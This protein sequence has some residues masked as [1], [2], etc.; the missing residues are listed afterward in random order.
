M[1]TEYGTHAAWDALNGLLGQ[2]VDPKHVLNALQDLQALIDDNNALPPGLALDS[3]ISH[4]LSQKKCLTLLY[5]AGKMLQNLVSD[6]CE[7]SLNRNPRV[8]SKCLDFFT[9]LTQ[10]WSKDF[11]SEIPRVLPVSVH[12]LGRGGSVR[13]AACKLLVA[14]ANA[15]EMEPKVILETI[16]EQSSGAGE[17]KLRAEC[18]MALQSVYSST[19]FASVEVHA[20]ALQ[21]RYVYTALHHTPSREL[22]ADGLVLCVL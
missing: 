19:N 20:E 3:S 7:C 11:T 10:N 5:L 21:V 9:N 22:V 1:A 18:C 15:K 6:L 16:A 14:M 12:A 2:L 13:T 4:H 17:S 8:S